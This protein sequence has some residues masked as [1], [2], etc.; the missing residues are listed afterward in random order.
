M[1]KKAHG[2]WTPEPL[3]FDHVAIS[4]ATKQDV[5]ALKD[6][7]A[8]A[9]VEVSEVVDHGMTGSLYF[10][11]PNNIPLEAAW[12]C[13]EILHT[14][15]VEDDEPRAL[16]AEGAGPQPGVW[17]AV[18]HPTPPEQMTAHP[19]AGCSMR[20][21]CARHGLARPLPACPVSPARGDG[22]TMA[23]PARDNGEAV[24]RTQSACASE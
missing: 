22:P 10:F 13:I 7:L 20:A 14:P 4:V 9:G 6:R 2:A 11:D 24:Q 17:S 12:D 8:A 18:T 3:G 1:R 16:V 21:C 5:F 23:M 19:G 15:A